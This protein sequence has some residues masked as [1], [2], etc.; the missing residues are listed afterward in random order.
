MGAK[1]MVLRFLGLPDL[2]KRLGQGET[3]RATDPAVL[4]LHATAT[5]HKQLLFAAT[6]VSPGKKAT[7][8]L[9]A[10]LNVCGWTLKSNGRVKTRGADRGV[11]LY[12]ASPMPVPAGVDKTRLEAVFLAELKAELKATGVDK[13]QLEAVFLGELK[14]AMLEA[15]FLAELKAASAGSKNAPIEKPIG[16]KKEPPLPP[17]PHRNRGF[18]SKPARRTA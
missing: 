17:P 9:R 1:L 7:G 14:A 10:L 12:E 5:A 3:I 18:A 6:G 16:G 15:A 2:L 8:T 11:Y 13:S 4:K